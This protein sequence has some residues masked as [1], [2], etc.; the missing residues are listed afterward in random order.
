[1]EFGVS[2]PIFGGSN[3]SHPRTPMLDK[4]DW[5]MILRIVRS[6]EK[7]GFDSIWVADHLMLGNE[8]QILEC[9]VTLSAL[10]TKTK[11][12]RLGTIHICN[13]F[14]NPALL[15]KMAATLDLISDG[16]L[17][18][19]IEA[20]HLG[21][22]RE[23]KAYGFNWPDNKTRAEILD[24]SIQI[25]KELWTGEPVTF[26]GKYFKIEEAVCRPRPKQT[27]HPPVWIGTIGGEQWTQN[28][29]MDQ[30][31]LSLIV[32]HA[33]VW[34]N[35]P[36]SVEY[37]AE[38]IS[39]LRNACLQQNRDPNTL[40]LSLETQVLLSKTQRKLEEKFKQ[41]LERNPK[42]LYYAN[43]QY[44]NAVYLVGTPNQCVEKIR[45]YQRLGIDKF[46]LWFVDLPSEDGLELFAQ[47]IIPS[48]KRK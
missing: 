3:D 46:L 31:M 33:D 39:Q 47:E 5:K 1:M 34:N 7:L 10:S 32:K 37:C 27:P 9:W 28:L 24:E 11:K 13:I 35:T 14:R 25:I 26:E 20:G 4:P 41:L 18:F 45:A 29:G 17:E 36:A 15:A 8:D 16:R 38:K 48:F 44:T 42:K 19:F 43:Q 22:T 23:A 6:A 30:I 2:L 12:L 21:S 40:K